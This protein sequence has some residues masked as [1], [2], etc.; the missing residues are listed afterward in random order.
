MTG[1]DTLEQRT[2]TLLQLLFRRQ[3]CLGD[4][5]RAF[6]RL[7]AEENALRASF[8][9]RQG[10]AFRA[11]DLRDLGLLTRAAPGD[12]LSAYVARVADAL[13]DEGGAWLS[14]AS[15]LCPRCLRERDQWLVGWELRFADAC[16]EHG[17]WLVD[18]CD[19]GRLLTW[20]R[21]SLWTC[22]CGR[23]VREL[24]AVACPAG[25][26]GLARALRARL[27]GEATD[28]AAKVLSGLSVTAA[29]QVIEVLGRFGNP[30]R[31]HEHRSAVSERMDA[32]WDLTSAA[33]QLLGDW[34]TSFLQ[35]MERFQARAARTGRAGR[36][37]STFG[38]LYGRLYR[39][40]P[41][42]FAP[43]RAV[44]ERYLTE[45]WRGALG[46][47][48]TR[49]A[50]VVVDRARWQPVA[51]VARHLRVT[52]AFAVRQLTRAG[53]PLSSRA[54]PSGRTFVVARKGTGDLVSAN[55]R[56]GLTLTRAATLLG[57]PKG[58]VLELAAERLIP[59]E[60]A[61]G[62]SSPWS[63]SREAVSR[64]AT[65]RSAAPVLSDCPEGA[66]AIGHILRYWASGSGLSQEILAALVDG[67][68]QVV[69]ALSSAPGIGGLLVRVDQA[70]RI[71]DSLVL[72]RLSGRLTVPAAAGE[73]RIKQEVAYHLV[74]KGL[75]EAEVAGLGA[76]R[77]RAVVSAAALE[78][79]RT[80]YRFGRDLAR[81]IQCSP[82]TLAGSLENLGVLP[83]AGPRVDGCRQAVY[84]NDDA[85]ARALKELHE[86]RDIR[87]TKDPQR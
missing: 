21:R 42:S 87:A 54:S 25:V 30:G 83:V 19:C 49:L 3:V 65:A 63:L 31:L 32:S 84:L 6:L 71:S 10:V 73:L 80:G 37:P 38:P 40:M 82:K 2:A 24:A 52:T 17:V 14:L 39:G 29:Q 79:F 51:H 8:L 26:G 23:A 16:P 27:T 56:D 18:R 20:R 59:A 67:R 45:N 70:R 75:L 57:L 77:G 47:R 36:L 12:G 78:A 1:A 48:N 34:P 46:R 76:S 74:R 85:L 86:R 9:S 41:P 53:V 69:G 66:L 15:R 35:A 4:G 58:R 43:M 62:F 28:F 81:S 72:N 60:R 55:Q 5:P 61:A 33:A 44:F 7:V 68:L 22:V 50:A 11:D 13:R 64:L